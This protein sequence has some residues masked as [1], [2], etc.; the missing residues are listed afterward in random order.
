MVRVVKTWI[1]NICRVDLNK[2]KRRH[3]E[4]RIR[5]K[6][7]NVR[8]AG[9][10]GISCKAMMNSIHELKD[11]FGS[12]LNAVRTTPYGRGLPPLNPRQDKHYAIYLVK[13]RRGNRYNVAFIFQ[14]V[15][16]H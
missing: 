2:R 15:N 12:L 16:V 13:E 10:F 3:C 9:Y 7:I 5:K 14:N 1:K 11:E 8:R 6:R 4:I